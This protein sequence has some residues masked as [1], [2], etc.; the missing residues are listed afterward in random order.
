VLSRGKRGQ[1]HVYDAAELVKW[2]VR[3][4]V[5]QLTTG[6][7]GTVLDLTAERARLAR[8]QSEWT[9][10]RTAER[11][12][13]LAPIE[14][15]TWTL[16]KVGAQIAATLEAIP[17]NCKRANP[18]LGANDVEII[19]R[20]IIKCQN[21]AARIEIDLDEYYGTEPAEHPVEPEVR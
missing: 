16:S 13:D 1:P 2:R 3:Q 4:E 19:K 21:A 20:E 11:R 15:I 10:L 5:A 12:K 9:E 7:D 17:L 14:L 18:R 6:D 8:A